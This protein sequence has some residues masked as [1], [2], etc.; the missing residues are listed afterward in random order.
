MPLGQQRQ[1]FLEK[2]H[3]PASGAAVPAAQPSMQQEVLL[4]QH[5]Q[6]RMMRGPS[7]LV[8][9]RPAQ[10]TL[11]PAIA[12][13]H[14]GV[15]IKT[16]SRCTFRKPC[17]LPSPQAREKSLALPLPKTLEQVAQGVVA[18]KTRQAQYLVQRRVGTQQTGVC[19]SSRSRQHGQQERRE[20]LRRI[21][22]IGR[23]ETKRQGL[24]HRLDVAHLPQKLE[25]HHQPAKRGDRSLGLAQFHF[26][27]APKRGNFGRHCFVL[28]GISFIQ[29]KLNRV[30]AKQ[31]YSI[32]E[33]RLSWALDGANGCPPKTWRLLQN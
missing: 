28:L 5:R 2:F 12:F 25:E 23:S 8:R 21:E 22:R 19:K 9:I 20:G 33:F 26:S 1:R 24:L 15:Q 3:H 4:G 13:K 29:L 32:S 27:P 30:R 16:V 14:S 11:L 31:C 10:R 17:E 7:M 6:Q 18:G